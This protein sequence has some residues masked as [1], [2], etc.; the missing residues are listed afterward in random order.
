MATKGLLLTGI[1]GFLAVLFC[2]E[3]GP[4]QAALLINRNCSPRLG[5]RL[6]W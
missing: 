3:A 6:G 1:G 2:L 4:A 5:E